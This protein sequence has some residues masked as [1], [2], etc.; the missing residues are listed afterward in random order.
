[1][2]GMTELLFPLAFLCMG[3]LSVDALAQQYVGHYLG[4][5][6]TTDF[7]WRPQQ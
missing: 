7:Q 6:R 3:C 5:Q 2:A 4:P 1:M